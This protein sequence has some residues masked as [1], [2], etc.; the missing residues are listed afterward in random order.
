MITP[1]AER[2]HTA[3]YKPLPKYKF[4]IS[5]ASSPIATVTRTRPRSCKHC[6]HLFTNGPPRLTGSI[7]S[8]LAYAK[9]RC[10][11]PE[12]TK[13]QSLRENHHSEA[14][15]C[16]NQ[17]SRL[18]KRVEFAKDTSQNVLPS[19]TKSL[20]PHPEQPSVIESSFSE[21]TTSSSKLP[22]LKRCIVMYCSLCSL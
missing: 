9:C 10:H 6:V 21:L 18:H 16:K 7:H 14:T 11:R 5:P 15:S 12:T 2:G 3:A 1:A 19:L 17:A 22:T 8:T 20:D 13:L 4:H